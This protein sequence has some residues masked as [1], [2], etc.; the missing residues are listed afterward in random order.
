MLL[1]LLA[2]LPQGP[3]TAPPAAEA[4]PALQVERLGLAD[5]SFAGRQ[6]RAA[7][8]GPVTPQTHA[9]FDVTDFGAVPGDGLPDRVAIQT[10][11]EAAE[12]SP[13][14]ALVRFPAGRFLLRG[15]EEVGAEGLRI[16]RSDIVLAG[17]GAQPGGTELFLAAESHNAYAV[18]IAPELD[19]TVGWRGVGTITDL[20]LHP[21]KGDREVQVV[22]AAGIEPGDIVRL[23][24]VLPDD[25]G[26]F[27]AF[28]DPLG[29]E[30]AIQ[31]YFDQSSG[32]GFDW[33]SDFLSTLEVES[34]TGNTVRFT[35]PLRADYAFVS[36]T[37]IGGPKLVQIFADG[38]ALL[39]DV[40]IQDLAF[41][42]N[43]RDSFKH[44][45]HRAADGYNFVRFADTR[46][47]WVRRVRM[48][49]GTRGI[50]FNNN[51]RNNVVHDV[52]FEGNSGHYTIT[53][54]GNQTGNQASYL[55]E[56]SPTHHGFGAT[57]S[58]FGTVYHRCNHFA[59]PEGHGGYPQATLY[60]CNAGD[61]SVSRIGGAPP[62]QSKGTVFWNWNQHL[63]LPPT[64]GL[65][66]SDGRYLALDLTGA[67]VSF[68]PD[69]IMRPSLVGLHG[70]P[71]AVEDPELD[72]ELLVG[73][74][75]RVE[76]ESLFE[77]QLER[78][79]GAVPAWLRQRSITFETISRPT[80][81]RIADA[82][83]DAGIDL[84][85]TL[86]VG[87]AL[88]PDFPAAYLTT[89]RLLAARGH[90]LDFP[91][92]VVAQTADPAASALAWTPDGA[93]PWRYRLV[94]ENSLGEQ[95]SSEER[96]VFVRPPGTT[97]EF[98]PAEDGWLQPRHFDARAISQASEAVVY[99]NSAQYLADV[100]A[101]EQ[102]L[103][104]PDIDSL[105]YRQV[106]LD[107]IDGD[108]F[109]NATGPAALRFFGVKGLVFDLGSVQRVDFVQLIGPTGSDSIEL[110]GV[111]DVQ[112][113]SDPGAQYSY[114]GSDFSW[115]TVRRFGHARASA[116][117]PLNAG[118]RTR[119]YLPQNSEARY[120]RLLVRT[121][122]SAASNQGNLAEVRFGQDQGL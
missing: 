28:F 4:T 15:P 59:G 117:L 18:Q 85:A 64:W 30:Q 118:R 70:V 8:I 105:T 16:R 2:L 61:L 95:A 17:A 29:D 14:P 98:L 69:R 106:G 100:R 38:D 42:S 68:W 9:T 92:A 76:P 122:D 82:A 113:S 44:F 35:D 87:I 75:Q 43:Y 66:N 89:V 53:S 31:Q 27:G 79:L 19:P 13:G 90:D 115:R 26:A 97:V 96:Y 114:T 37:F 45:F 54:D 51:G 21:Q 48:R 10:A 86:D 83:G 3:V 99:Q 119:I 39:E 78:R 71:L 55:R 56:A 36:T 6:S 108:L 101:I 1:S 112:V 107:L 74:G 46:E 50:F 80:Q 47:C 103:V 81:I 63:F 102:P 111:F 11:I 72:V 91:E 110:S 24:G 121:L 116:R 57:S 22:N 62:H 25:L 7:A 32:G 52:L 120:V 93:G 77:H 94:L 33:R 60:D 12:A 5:Y 58:S 104:Q 34:V 84:G 73:Q 23:S 109:T 20:S 49:S 40:G 41:V 65:A 88:H 67:I